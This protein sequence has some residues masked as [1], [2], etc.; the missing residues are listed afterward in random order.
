MHTLTTQLV[1]YTTNYVV[2]VLAIAEIWCFIL[3]HA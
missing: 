1:M 3:L 2:I